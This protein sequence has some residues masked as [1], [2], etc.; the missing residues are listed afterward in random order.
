MNSAERAADWFETRAPERPATLPKLLGCLRLFSHSDDL[1]GAVASLG[2]QSTAGA[3][4]VNLK[5][6]PFACAVSMARSAR[7]YQRI[8]TT[9]SG[10]ASFNRAPVPPHSLL[11]TF[12][13]LR[14]T[15]VGFVSHIGKHTS[16]GHYVCHMHLGFSGIAGAVGRLIFPARRRGEGGS[17]VIFDDS[18][19]A[20][21]STF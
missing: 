14:Y 10:S 3:S 8:M 7:H 19:A 20:H 4:A 11:E 18:K 9:A 1:D 13:C 2:G 16:H 15:L 12:F 6:H 21:L 17:W 5:A